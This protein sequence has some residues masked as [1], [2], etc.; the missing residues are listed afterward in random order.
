MDFSSWQVQ[1]ENELEE[2]PVVRMEGYT[3]SLNTFLEP[4]Y[5]GCWNWGQPANLLEVVQVISNSDYLHSF[6]KNSETG[7][8]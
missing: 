6:T 1:C 2:N 7:M 8:E 5:T 3:Y 4:V